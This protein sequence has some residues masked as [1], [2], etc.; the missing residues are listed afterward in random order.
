MATLITTHSSQEATQRKLCRSMVTQVTT[1]TLLMSSKA[2]LQP[3]QMISLLLSL[4][5]QTSPALK[6][7]RKGFLTMQL[8]TTRGQSISLTSA[9]NSS[10]D[11]LGWKEETMR[12]LSPLLKRHRFS[13]KSLNALNFRLQ[14]KMRWLLTLKSSKN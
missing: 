8:G 2:R 4:K 14:L 12:I 7:R 1:K 13:T 9:L 3:S 6:P 10:S 5:R 11:A